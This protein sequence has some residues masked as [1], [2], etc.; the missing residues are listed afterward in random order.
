LYF[1]ALSRRIPPLR[2][3]FAESGGQQEPGT[4]RGTQG[5]KEERSHSAKTV[6]HPDSKTAE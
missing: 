4:G 3:L 2:R 6:N 5:G 1:F